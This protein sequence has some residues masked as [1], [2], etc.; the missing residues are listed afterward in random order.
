MKYLLSDRRT[1]IAF[2]SIVLLFILGIKT[3]S[4]DVAI[5]IASIACGLAGANAWEKRKQNN[6]KKE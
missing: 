4:V 5:S 2:I 6:D 3:N 1:F